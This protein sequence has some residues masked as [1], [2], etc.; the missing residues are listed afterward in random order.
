MS[1]D[2]DQYARFGGE[3]LRPAHDLVAAVPLASPAR[4]A[5]LGCGDGRATQLLAARWPAAR[6]VGV[7]SSQAMLD[8]AA[9]LGL[10]ATWQCAG[11]DAWRP[12]RPFDLVFSNAALHWLSG[13]ETLFPRLAEAVTPGGTLAVQMPRNFAAPSHAAL[14]DLAESP[15]WRSRLAGLVRRNPVEDPAWY[16]D[17]LASRMRSVEIW[18]TEYLHALP[19]ELPVVDWLKGTWLRP[20][21][22]ALPRE[23]ADAFEAEYADLMAAAYPRRADGVTLFPFRRLFIV[24]MR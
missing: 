20:F 11:I 13:H 9:R 3:R 6:I 22:D 24:A 2:P 10:D 21:L 5:D 4:I 16:Y 8:A 15:R 1:W 7:D 14:F 12:D 19:G 18:E 17:V 23:E